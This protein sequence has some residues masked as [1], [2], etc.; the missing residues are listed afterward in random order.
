MLAFGLTNAPAIF[1][2]LMSEVLK[3]YIDKSVVV[4][5]GDIAVYSKTKQQHFQHAR[6]VLKRLRREK[7]SASLSKCTFGAD[8]V[9]RLGHHLT[10]DGASADSQKIKVILEWPNPK[11]KVDVQ[12][13]LGIVNC[14]RTFIKNRPKIAKHLSRWR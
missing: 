3:E 13:L 6:L 4:Y 2:T 7:L 14:Y 5:L 8:S 10:S 1:P 9:E 11:T 12:S